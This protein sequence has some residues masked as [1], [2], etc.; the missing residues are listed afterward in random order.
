MTDFAAVARQYDQS[1]PLAELRDLFHVPDGLIYLDG[2]SLGLMPR[3]T[4]GRVASVVADEW[5]EGLIGSWREAGWMD[6]PI[7]V[8]D[9]IAPLI[10]VGPGEVA[11]G[12]STSVN[13]FKCL[14]AA[15]HVRPGRGVILAEEDNFPT[16]NY[17]CSGLAELS[18]QI[19]VRYLKPGG[20]IEEAL[21]D[22]V[23]VVILSH[24]HYRSSLVRD[25]AE[26]NR[27]AHAAGALVLWDL[28]HSTGA[29]SVD[30]KA[31]ESDF[32]VGCSYKYLNGGPGAPAFVWVSEQ[33]SEQVRQ[34]LSGWMGHN[35]P[36]A[37]TVDYQPADGIRR[38][39]CGTPQV[40]SLAAL[41]ESLKLWEQVDTTQLFAK[42]AA[43]TE[44]FIDAVEQECG[45]FELTLQSPRD[46][47]VRGSH[48]SFGFSGGAQVMTALA[49]RGIV[50]DFRPPDTM[51]FGIAPLYL[52]MT[53]LAQTAT[54][55]RE[56]LE[57][58]AS[59][60]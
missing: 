30:L 3:S 33:L 58:A 35:D 50:G 10:G 20:S 7:T 1:D 44:F 45:E 56:E 8:G 22:D 26:L 49:K 6:L 17:I 46:P 15:L 52:R 54:A 31:T 37:F 36:F 14:A 40:L 28:S 21:D 39:V 27:S 60:R 2:N 5:A 23:A 4:N 11:V 53:D 25:M 55:M 51:R 32:A 47:S 38:F 29:L 24:V 9:R 18:D 42:T 19:E 16:D 43:M 34:P 57:A 48:V 12:D 13:L 59:D 41:D